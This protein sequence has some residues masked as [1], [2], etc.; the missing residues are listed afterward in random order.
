MGLTKH[1]KS[2]FIGDGFIV[3]QSAFDPS[4]PRISAW[5][6]G[7]WERCGLSSHEPESWPER[8][9]LPSDD[10]LPFKEVAPE[11]YEK[12]MCLLGGED[13]TKGELCLHNGFICN[14]GIGRD[15]PWKELKDSGGWHADGDFFRHFLDSPEQSCLIGSYYTDVGHQGGAT[16]I[17]PG[18]HQVVAKFLA[19]H[20]EGVLP[21][22]VG[23]NRLIEKC[24][25][26]LELTASAG[27]IVIMHPFM[28]HSSSQ[29]KNGQVRLMNNNNL[30]LKHNLN[31][32]RPDQ[33]YSLV[34]SAI[35]NALHLQNLDFSIVGEREEIIPPRLR[36][37]VNADGHCP[38][39]GEDATSS[40]R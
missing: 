3:V 9:H 31:F 1:E 37:A 10:S 8:V 20:P 24:H 30:G 19:E 11:A 25:Q 13:R 40:C 15:E 16:L 2:K 29:N 18:S 36:Q 17:S 12:V 6:E 27:D 23:E 5:I 22:F 34:E 32:N 33:A 39:M 21:D 28:L 35:L 38:P 26:F 4:H 7:V 14:F